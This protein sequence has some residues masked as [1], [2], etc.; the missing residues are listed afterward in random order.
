MPPGSVG[1]AQVG[2]LRSEKEA[3]TVVLRT[4]EDLLRNA[5]TACVC[6]CV[7]LLLYGMGGSGHCSVCAATG[8]ETALSEA[9][10]P[11]VGRPFQHARV[12]FPPAMFH[13]QSDFC[14]LDGSFSIRFVFS[15]S[16][17]IKRPIGFWLEGE[18]SSICFSLTSQNTGH[19]TV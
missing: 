9:H 16:L 8:M 5:P 11:R 14:C 17:W 13:F 12:Y 19:T 7:C 6:V 18:A 15:R 3:L 10:D 1:R 2:A 4:W